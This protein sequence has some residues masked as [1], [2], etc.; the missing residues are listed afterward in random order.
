MKLKRALI[1]KSGDNVTTVL[2][3]IEVGEEVVTRLDR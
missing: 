3:N 1:I 2:E